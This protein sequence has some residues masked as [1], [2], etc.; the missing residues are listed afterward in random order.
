MS[1]P[2]SLRGRLALVAVCACAIWVF[3][4]TVILNLALGSQLRG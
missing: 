1:R 2:K 3:G 4:L